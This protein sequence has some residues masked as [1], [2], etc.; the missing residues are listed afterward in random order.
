MRIRNAI[1]IFPKFENDFF[2]QQIRAR[3]DP[4]ASLIDPHITLVF[5]YESDFPIKQLHTHIQHAIQGIRP[6]EINL[7]GVTGSESEYLFLNIKCGNDQIIK[8][9]DCLYS[10]LLESHL[11]KDHTYIP[12]LTVGRLN[13]QTAFLTALETAQNLSGVFSTVINEI[14]LIRVEENYPI[15]ARFDLT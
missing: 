12:H 5:P 9:H 7:Q 13:D 15:E 2:I 4:L 14:S 1:V 11:K 3:F 10:G 6:F 8:L